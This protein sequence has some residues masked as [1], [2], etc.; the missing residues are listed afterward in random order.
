MNK[1]ARYTIV[2]HLEALMRDGSIKPEV[3][4][5]LIKFIDNAT[6]EKNEDLIK[7]LVQKIQD[8]EDTM[9][10]EDKSLYTLG[11]RQAVD[12]LR[13]DSPTHAKEYKPLDEEDFRPKEETKDF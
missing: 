11:I 7:T 8:W 6:S 10:E 2:A 3:V 1:D 5:S 13:G 9:G 4:P 12:V